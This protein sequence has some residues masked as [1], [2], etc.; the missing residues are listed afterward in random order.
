[1]AESFYDFSDMTDDE[2]LKALDKACIKEALAEVQRDEALNEQY[3]CECEL[4]A[5][6]VDF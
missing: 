3:L 4:E 2:V 5:R 1:M 6:G